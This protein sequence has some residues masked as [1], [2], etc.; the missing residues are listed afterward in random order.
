MADVFTR[1]KRSEIMSR[2]K[3]RGNLATELALVSLLRAQGLSGWRRHAALFGNPDFIFPKLRIALFVDG[4][5]W[6]GCPLHGSMPK[7]NHAFWKS[8]IERNSQRDHAVNAKLK[9]LG[10]SP[11]RIWQ[12]ELRRPERLALRLNK[13]LDRK[14]RSRNGS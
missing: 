9:Q 14:S 5:F 7:T 1:Q 8:K 4:C 6:H 12:H 3:G 13:L 10:W 11:V 2:V